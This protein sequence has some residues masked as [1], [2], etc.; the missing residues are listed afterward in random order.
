MFV[1]LDQDHQHP[2]IHPRTLIIHLGSRETPSTID[3][4]VAKA[5]GHER[6]YDANGMHHWM[7]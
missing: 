6:F 7:M 1:A 2:Q 3:G 5:A 4:R